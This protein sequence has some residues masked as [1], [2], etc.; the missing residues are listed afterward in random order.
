[1]RE[2]VVFVVRQ[3]AITALNAAAGLVVVQALPKGEYA[4]Y[5][6]VFSFLAVFVNISNVGITPAMSGIGGRIWQDPVALRAL[7]N[8]ALLLRRKI[9]W[10]LLLPFVAYCTW[11]FWKAGAGWF[12]TA[13]LIGF[14]LTAI[15]LQVQSAL[16]A[17]VLQL[18]KAVRP[19]Q[20]NELA[21]TALKV[22]GILPMLF[23]QAPVY[24]LVGWICVCLALNLFANQKLARR[25]LAVHPETNPKFLR[26]IEDIARPNALRT[27][28]WAFEGQISVLLC[29]LFAQPE[30]I[31]DIGALGRL[32]VLFA[33]FQ[34][35]VVNFSLPEIAKAQDRAAIV[36]QARKTL[37]LA[38]LLVAP[39]LLWAAVHPSSLLCILGP[40]YGSLTRLLLPFL[41]AVSLGQM[42]AVTYQICTARAWIRLNRFYVPLALPLQVL[43][44]AVLDLSQLENV[45]LLL[46]I[47]NL[48]FL[49]FNLT[50]FLVEMK[51][52]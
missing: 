9:G 42:A 12:T 18:H 2:K 40:N 21:F 20:Q 43:L 29:A 19:L 39:V 49:L 3:T 23:F 7:L 24:V 4:L 32:S 34:A 47:N 11:Q 38:A 46:G 17:I 5:T 8:S 1:M 52:P 27:A 44:I 41:L 33:I 26:E 36:S 14:V 48:F 37:G 25:Y 15:W 30:T 35:F 51:K 10:W 6:L 16:Y 50:M 13:L 45:V 28:Y 31:A 22:L